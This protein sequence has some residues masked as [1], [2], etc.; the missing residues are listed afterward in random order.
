MLHSGHAGITCSQGHSPDCDSGT[1][2]KRQKRLFPARKM[3]F[4][5]ETPEK[6][7]QAALLSVVTNSRGFQ[8][9]DPQSGPFHLCNGLIE[10]MKAKT[11]LGSCSMKS[12]DIARISGSD[13][14]KI[15]SHVKAI[16]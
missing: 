6:H 16:R 10:P 2:S 1:G 8:L 14:L 15:Q 13:R 5:S 9:Q 4:A 3:R 12:I 11:G 7:S